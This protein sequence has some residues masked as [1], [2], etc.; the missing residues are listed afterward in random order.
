MVRGA[1]SIVLGWRKWWKDDPPTPQ[2]FTAP[3]PAAAKLARPAC[4]TEVAGAF[5]L[6]RVF[7]LLR[8]TENSFFFQ[9]QDWLSAPEGESPG[10]D[11]RHL[12][13][14]RAR[15][16]THTHRHTHTHTQT[17]PSLT[18]PNSIANGP[19]SK[20]SWELAGL[21]ES[22]LPFSRRGWRDGQHWTNISSVGLLL[23]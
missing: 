2:L 7:C 6:L 9:A 12:H 5:Y 15:A 18:D 14:A 23:S 22:S 4:S 11:L 1:F 3:H 20:D 16:R 8:N 17:F 10:A 19:I 13:L 21:L